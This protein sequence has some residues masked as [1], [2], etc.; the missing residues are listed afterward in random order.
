MIASRE[1]SLNIRKIFPIMFI[2]Y[3]YSERLAP[4]LTSHSIIAKILN[5]IFLSHYMRK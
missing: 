1:T 5:G 3:S 4:L 2:S